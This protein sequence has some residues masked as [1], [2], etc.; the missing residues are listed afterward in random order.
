MRNFVAKLMLVLVLLVS[1]GEAFAATIPTGGTG[2]TGGA[3]GQQQLDPNTDY[4]QQLNQVC[5]TQVITTSSGGAG[6]AGGQGQNQLKFI[7]VIVHCFETVIEGVAMKAMASVSAGLMMAVNSAMLFYVM[8]FGMKLITGQV[9]SPKGDLIVHGIK[10]GFVGW[11]VNN[12]GLYELWTMTL[13]VY[14]NMLEIMITPAT[15]QVC[16]ASGVGLDMVWD[17]M[18]CLFAKL[19]GFNEKNGFGSSWQGIMLLL[20]TAV[21]KA[22]EG[23]AYMIS[24]FIANALLTILF[25]FLQIALS[26]IISMLGLT[27]LFGIAPLMLPMMFFRATQTYFEAWW[28]MALSFILQ[29]SILFAF[30]SFAF[31]IMEQIYSGPDGLQS[32]FSQTKISNEVSRTD[33]LG[34]NTMYWQKSVASLTGQAG[35]GSGGTGGTSGGGSGA[36][37]DM[38]LVISTIS[39]LVLGYLMLSFINVIGQ[40]AH[41]ISGS[42]AFP[43]VM[44]SNSDMA[45]TA[46]SILKKPKM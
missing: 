40:I 45:M 1:S 42:S 38:S 24:A 17:T 33:T 13:G 44:A 31:A 22:S 16:P 15:L 2:G 36:S 8:L 14:Q 25:S 7:S 20:S 4:L 32:V 39:M 21:S 46:Q 43:N 18:D 26:Y 3:G 35:G 27:L 41:E 34:T 37:G 10:L 19:T 11:A 9:N 30:V 5:G 28:R 29:V 23:G 12:A 6:G